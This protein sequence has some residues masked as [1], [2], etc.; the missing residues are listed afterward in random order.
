M[1]PHPKAEDDIDGFHACTKQKSHPTGGSF[2]NTFRMR[3]R[4]FSGV[5]FLR[6]QDQKGPDLTKR[7]V[8]PES[9]VLFGTVA[10]TGPVL[11]FGARTSATKTLPRLFGTVKS[12][13]VALDRR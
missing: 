1:K 4:L 12:A 5:A 11:P 7:A 13:I 10:S 8:E 9:G 2:G 3:S 6:T